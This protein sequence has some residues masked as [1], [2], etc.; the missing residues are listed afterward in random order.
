MRSR[1]MPL[2][3]IR[4][5]IRHE[6][7]RQ[8]GCIRRDNRPGLAMLLHALE[9]IPFDLEILSDGLDNPIHFS[10]PSQIVIEVP[11][12]DKARRFGRKK[13]CR[14]SLFRRLQSSAND[15]IS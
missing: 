6:M 10:A 1:P 11:D 14:T 15:A 5:A 13:S 4:T 2:E 8:T 7:N 12:G 3:I 9:K